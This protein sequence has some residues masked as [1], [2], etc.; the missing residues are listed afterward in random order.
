[1]P[2]HGGR[3][4]LQ[5]RGDVG[6]GDRSLLHEQAGDRLAGATVGGPP[7]LDG[8]TDGP[9]NGGAGCFHNASVAYIAED[10]KGTPRHG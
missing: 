9:E 7:R 5:R 1:M 3:G 8:H 4:Q 6:R 2:A 10:G